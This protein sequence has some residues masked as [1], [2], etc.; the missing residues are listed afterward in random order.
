MLSL[1]IVMLL[2]GA[3][4]PVSQQ[5]QESLQLK[6]ERV[7]AYETMY[8]GA[9][10]MKASGSAE[11]ERLVDGV[12]YSWAIGVSVCVEYE[13]YKGAGEILCLD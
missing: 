13:N 7:A 8:E 12:V 5:L 6:K 9:K 11:G 10:E 2:F 1:F 3:V 4:L